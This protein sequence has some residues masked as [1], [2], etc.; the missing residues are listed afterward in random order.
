MRSLPASFFLF[1]RPNIIAAAM[2]DSMSNPPT[3]AA[4][5]IRILF[6]FFFFLHGVESHKSKFSPK[7]AF[8]FR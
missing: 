3:D 5:G 7:L 4:I 2:N 8:A 6:F 1:F